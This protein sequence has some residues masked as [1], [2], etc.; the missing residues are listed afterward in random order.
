MESDAICCMAEHAEI[1]GESVLQLP[2]AF[3]DAAYAIEYTQV[4]ALA[5]AR[6]A[7]IPLWHWFVAWLE[8]TSEDEAS[9]SERPV[10]TQSRHCQRNSA[11]SLTKG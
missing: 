4:P 3:V 10:Q 7:V 5:A 1:W 8:L 6:A 2:K 9:P 11:T